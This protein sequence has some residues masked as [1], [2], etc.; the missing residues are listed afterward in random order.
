[1]AHA[2][3]LSVNRIDKARVHK[4]IWRLNNAGVRRLVR[5]GEVEWTLH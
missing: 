3:A 1:V 2:I 4:T 5:A